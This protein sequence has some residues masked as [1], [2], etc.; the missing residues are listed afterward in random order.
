MPLP[1]PG[2]PFTTRKQAILTHLSAPAESYID[3][4]PKGSVDAGIRHLIDALNAREGLVTTS[5]C[6]GRVSVYLEG[7]KTA[8]VV[9][10]GA[11]AAVAVLGGDSPGEEGSGGDVGSAVGGKGGGEWLFMSHDPVEGGG[12]EVGYEALLLGREAGVSGG[13]EEMGEA[14]GASRLIHFK[15][16]PM[17]CFTHTHSLTLFVWV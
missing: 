15:F 11:A 6:A 17:V 1:T 16:E 2:V 13:G 14:D 9:T 12:G 10:G 7:R 8:A 4:S 3:A 5:S